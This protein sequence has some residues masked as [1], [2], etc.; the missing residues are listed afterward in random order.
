MQAIAVVRNEFHGIFN[1]IDAVLRD[2]IQKECAWIVSIVCKSLFE[3]AGEFLST[4]F[5][6]AQLVIEACP[7]EQRDE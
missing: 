2:C 1:L 3:Q 7:A 6:G 5:D 4:G